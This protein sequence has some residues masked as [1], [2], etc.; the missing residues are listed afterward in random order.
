MQSEQQPK[1][2]MADDGTVHES[3]RYSQED[4]GY[5]ISD[6]V[7]NPPGEPGREPKFKS[8]NMLEEALSLLD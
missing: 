2:L 5:M 6:A 4:R 8:P 3:F 1:V 7:N